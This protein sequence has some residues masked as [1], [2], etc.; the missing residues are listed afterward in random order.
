MTRIADA[1]AR[2]SGASP[3][4]D[5][6]LSDPWNVRAHS[7][8]EAG[9]ASAPHSIPEAR[10]AAADVV[11]IAS[12]RSPSPEYAER[13]VTSAQL[14]P[15]VVEHYRR[16]AAILHRAQI[17]QSLRVLM[18]ASAL[19]GEGKTI[20]ASN[21]ALTLAG[22]LGRRVLLVDADF[23]KP[24]L[25]DVFGLRDGPGLTDYATQGPGAPVQVTPTLSIMPAGTC[26]SDSLRTL[27]SGHLQRLIHDWA[28][29]YDWIILDTPPIALIADGNLLAALADKVLLVIEAGKTPYDVIQKSVERIGRERIVGCVL[30]RANGAETTLPGYEDFYGEPLSKR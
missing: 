16:L 1:L 23:R 10:S 2:E 17:D 19:P 3:V 21:L 22:S 20:V 12:H 8:V 14:A 27:T 11:S 18:I 26:R 7:P 6:V 9:P 13:L 5:D 25:Q 28:A 15:G 4:P 29:R 24:S 30:N